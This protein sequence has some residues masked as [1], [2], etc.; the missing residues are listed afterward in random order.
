MAAQK[1]IQIVYDIDGKA[2]DVAIDSTLNLKQQVRELTKEINKTK[3]G[4]KEF[5]LLSAKLNE[6][7]DNVDRVNAKSREFFSTLSLLPGPIGTFAN[8]IDGAISLLKTFS[9]FSLKDIRNQFGELGKDIS[10][11]FSN[12]LGLK[13]STDDVAKSTKDLGNAAS[14]TNNNLSQTATIAGTTAAAIQN[15]NKQVTTGTIFTDALGQKVVSLN[16]KYEDL[17][18]Q[19]KDFL[20]SGK[21]VVTNVEEFK[22]AADGSVVSLDNYISSTTKASF[23]TKAFTVT[24]NALKIALTGF[25]IGAVVLGLEKLISV[26]GEWVTG[27]A[28]AKAENERLTTSFDVLKRS[29][30]E[31][32]DAIKDQTDLLVLQAKIAG[33]T[34]EEIYQITKKGFDKRVEANKEGRKRIERELELLVGN[35]IL[36]EEDRI[37][38]QEDLQ[39]KYVD[40]G[41]KG[42]ELRIEGEK[43]ALQEELR[44]AEKGR[45]KQKEN[46]DKKLQQNKEYLQRLKQDNA[47]ADELLFQLGQENAV[48]RLRSEE[49][50]Q[51]QELKNAKE[52]EERKINALKISEEK[53]NLLL[54]QVREKY[55]YKVLDVAKKR[56]EDGLKLIDEY[57]TTK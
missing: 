20:K 54:A 13:S 1:K 53:R 12:F 49:E 41:I 28:A 43:L 23:A 18:K 25:V 8:Q 51:N 35:S 9:G 14:N 15:V 42:N 10:S 16:K 34:E 11:I 46:N 40:L 38:L 55:A 32:Q 30:D 47:A 56:E 5:S 6:T 36:K 37:K 39:K 4:T 45:A 22:D 33:K 2:I 27:A 26:I 50:R 21:Q 31:T 52:V 24:W 48:L 17:T 3:E 29:I 7:K 44:I 19:E 57:I